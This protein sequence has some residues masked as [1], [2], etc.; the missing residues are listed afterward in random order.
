[1]LQEKVWAQSNIQRPLRQV[2]FI[3]FFKLVLKALLRAIR[4]HRFSLLLHMRKKFCLLTLSWIVQWPSQDFKGNL[5]IYYMWVFISIYVSRDVGGPKKSNLP[6]PILGQ[7]LWRRHEDAASVASSK[8]FQ[9]CRNCSN[10]A[11]FGLTLKQI[12]YRFLSNVSV[13]LV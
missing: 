10:I 6:F 7:T 11:L 9:K 1:M 8:H 4:R 13:Y 5:D 12:A 2:S 3:K